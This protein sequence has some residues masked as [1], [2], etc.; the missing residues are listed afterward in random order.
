MFSF[1]QHSHLL[2][3]QTAQ[4]RRKKNCEIIDMR[5]REKRRRGGE[6]KRLVAEK[7]ENPFSA[8][9]NEWLG[10]KIQFRKFLFH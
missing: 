8:D 10:C 9:Q 5:E 6:K 7:H 4:K 3:I 2:D 1:Y